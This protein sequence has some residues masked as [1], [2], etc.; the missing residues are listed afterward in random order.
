[1]PIYTFY[2]CRADGFSTTFEAYELDGDAEALDR[3]ELLLRQHASCDFVTVW[4]GD[5]KVPGVPTAAPA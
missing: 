3:A 2:P 5:R 4:H 1:M